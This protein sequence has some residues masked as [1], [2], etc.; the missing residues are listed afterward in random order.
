MVPNLKHLL[1]LGRNRH[2][3]F[4]VENISILGIWGSYILKQIGDWKERSPSLLT[5]KQSTVRDMQ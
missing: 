2:I 4:L 1:D 5:G 3:H